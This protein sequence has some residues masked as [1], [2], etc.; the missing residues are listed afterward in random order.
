METLLL[1]LAV[2]ACPVGMAVAMWLMGRGMMSMGGPRHEHRASGDAAPSTGTNDPEKR[3]AVLQAEREL[4]EAQIARLE[5]S[6][7]REELRVMDDEAAR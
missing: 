1:P 6:K 7:R 5:E 4:V 2:L 3:L